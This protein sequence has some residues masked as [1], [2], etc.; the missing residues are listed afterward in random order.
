MNFFKL[1]LPTMSNGIVFLFSIF[2]ILLVSSQIGANQ[3][4]LTTNTVEGFEPASNSKSVASNIKIEKNKVLDSLHID[5][6]RN[7][8]E[9]IVSNTKTWA[10][11]QI[12]K[13][14][15]SDTIS[16]SEGLTDSNLI[17]IN[18]INSLKTFKSC[19]DDAYN[20]I[21]EN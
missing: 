12:L 2:L 3:H 9:D 6:Y 20:L 15:V 13:S 7:N 5:K 1:E 14:I 21:D 11:A 19:C 4:I 8:Y 16:T 18:H 10:D 17:K